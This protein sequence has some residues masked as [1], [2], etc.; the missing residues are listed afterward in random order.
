MDATQTRTAAEVMGWRGGHE[1]WNHECVW[2]DAPEAL[3]SSTECLDN[4]SEPTVDD[5]LAWLRGRGRVC[6]VRQIDR[7]WA[8]YRVTATSVASTRNT[9]IFQD[10]DT[11]QA[12]FEALVLVLGPR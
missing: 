6:D 10:A 4:P 11:L 3:T 8:A 7:E 12:A 5:M 2:C 1:F 9:G